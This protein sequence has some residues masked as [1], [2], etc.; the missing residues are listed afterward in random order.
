MC[1]TTFKEVFTELDSDLSTVKHNDIFSQRS[2]AYVYMIDK[3]NNVEG[4]TFPRN[5]CYSYRA[6]VKGEMSKGLCVPE[7]EFELA[8]VAKHRNRYADKSIDFCFLNRE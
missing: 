8:V 6:L 2:K 1:L 4:R 7:N 5:F 3:D